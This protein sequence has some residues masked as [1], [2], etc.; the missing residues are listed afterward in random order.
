[1]IQADFCLN[2]NEKNKKKTGFYRTFSQSELKEL[3][4]N[5]DPSGFLSQ[6]E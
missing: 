2:Q 1:M 6:S 5:Y 4:E 3:K